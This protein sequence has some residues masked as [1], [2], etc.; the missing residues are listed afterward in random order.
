VGQRIG[1]LVERLER[2][3]SF[4]FSSLFPHLE[5]DGA[6]SMAQ[7][8][9]E[10]VVTFLALLEMAKLRLIKLAQPE[11]EEEIRIAAAQDNLRQAVARS[12]ARDA[13][14]ADAGGTGFAD[15]YR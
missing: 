11:G 9:H 8:R 14:D 13:G 4:S 12:V 1:Q 7:L 3:G 10:V 2:E 5:D 15:D 6:L